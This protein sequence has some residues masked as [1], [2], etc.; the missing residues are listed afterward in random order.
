M[1]S[2][3]PRALAG[4]ARDIQHMASGLVMPQSFFACSVL[5]LLE[6]PIESGHIQRHV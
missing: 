4:S 1:V 6:L 5:G 2:K 3:M